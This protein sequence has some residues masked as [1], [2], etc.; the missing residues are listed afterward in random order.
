MRR[1]RRSGLTF[2]CARNLPLFLSLFYSLLLTWECY[3][4]SG[5]QAGGSGTEGQDEYM[6]HC[7]SRTFPYHHRIVLPRSAGRH[8][9]V[10]CVESRIVRGAP[11]MVEELENYVPPEV[12]KIVVG[13]KLDKCPHQKAQRS[14]RGRDVYSSRHRQTAEGV[15]E[16]FNEV[17]ARSSIRPRC[18]MRISPS[19]QEGRPPLLTPPPLVD[20]GVPQPRVC[21]EYRSV[22]GAGRGH[23]GRVF[24]L[25]VRRLFFFVCPIL[26]LLGRHNSD[27]HV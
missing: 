7:R 13:N 24:V 14:Q 5:T 1:A 4:M 2:G 25:A 27:L 23:V 6:G 8:T 9:R 22:S 19:R 20:R 3:C 11:A 21:R 26:R 18:G 17:V 16:A 15:T 12:V 10:R